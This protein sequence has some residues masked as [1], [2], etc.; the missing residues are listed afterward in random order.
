M[1]CDVKCYVSGK[2]FSVKCLAKD[3]NEAKQVAL[4]QHPNARIM[5]VTAVFDKVQS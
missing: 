1:Q 4:A 3:Y 5:G 2:V